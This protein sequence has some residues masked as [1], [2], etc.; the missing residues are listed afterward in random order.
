MSDITNRVDAY[1]DWENIRRR[2]SDNYIEKVTINQVMDAIRK[3]AN[4]I[5]QLRQGKFYGDFTLRREEAR[6][7]ERKPNFAFRNVLRST[8]GKDQADITIVSD[9]MEAVLTQHD[10]DSILLCSGDGGF[11]EP[12]RRASVRSIKIYVCAVGIDVSPDLSSLAPVYPIEKYLDTKLS[13]KVSDQPVLSG[14]SPKE[15]VRWS[16]FISILDSLESKLPFVA[17]G[18]FHKSIMLSYNLGGQTNDDRWSNIE[19]AKEADIVVI[20]TV[21]NPVRPGFK[22]R[23]LKLNRNN[24]L[25][26]EVLA[27]K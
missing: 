13:R 6:E 7:I 19:S 10:Y 20:E 5:G 18:Y 27:R 9:L 16:K 1:V 15:M 17:L 22:M 4:E 25:V 8:S 23:V 3:I 14:L 11:S 24:S 21:D 12:I 26:K 2:L